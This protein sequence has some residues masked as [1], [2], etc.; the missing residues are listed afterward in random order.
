MGF[1]PS[2]GY[3]ENPLMDFGEIFQINSGYDK[4]DRSDLL[5]AH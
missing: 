2:A 1:G 4:E 3:L 5:S